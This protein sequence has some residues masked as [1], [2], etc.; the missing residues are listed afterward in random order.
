MKI[1]VIGAG[2]IGSVYGYVL[3]QSGNEVTHYL[4]K[5]KSKHFENGIQVRLLD[6]RGKKP[7]KYE[8]VYYLKMT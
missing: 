1:M 6:E 7:E 3:A 2:V 5:G 4:R 8:T